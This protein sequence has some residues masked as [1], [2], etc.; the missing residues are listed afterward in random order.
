MGHRLKIQTQLS[1]EPEQKK[2]LEKLSKTTRIPMQVLMRE[3]ID[4]MLAKYRRKG[5]I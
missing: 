3:G 5:V 1:L 2:A 4:M